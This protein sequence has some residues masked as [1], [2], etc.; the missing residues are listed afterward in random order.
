[1]TPILAKS[2]RAA[3]RKLASCRSQQ[4]AWKEDHL[5]AMVVFDID[6]L[7]GDMVE[8]FNVISRLDSTFRRDV[9]AN[10]SFYDDRFDG[11][12]KLLCSRYLALSEEIASTTL[13]FSS[14]YDVKNREAF[15]KC[16]ESARDSAKRDFD[17]ESE[18]EYEQLLPSTSD[19]EELFTPIEQWPC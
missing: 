5:V 16:L 7:L 12:I 19:L 3:T 4:E 18:I 8:L 6:D 13:A 17:L 15:L 10:P 9:I 2:R 11:Q 1:M 14:E